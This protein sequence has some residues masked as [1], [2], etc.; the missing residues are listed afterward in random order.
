M[1]IYIYLINLLG[2]DFFKKEI[3][4]PTYSPSKIPQELISLVS[5]VNW[6]KMSKISFC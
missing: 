6:T 4:T 1:Y 5:T 3:L 2:N